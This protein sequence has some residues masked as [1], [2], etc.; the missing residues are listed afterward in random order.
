MQ[1]HLT[2]SQ[3]ITPAISHNTSTNSTTEEGLPDLAPGFSYLLGELQLSFLSIL[4]LNNYS[5]LLQWRRILTLILTST[6][7]VNTEPSLYISTL[8]LLRLQLSHSTDVEG[9]LFDFDDEGGTFLKTLLLRF[10]RGLDSL[11]G[12]TKAEVLEELEELQEWLAETHG[13][14]FDQG[15]GTFARSGVLELE[16][17]E[18]VDMDVGDFDEE[19]EEGEYAPMVVDLSDEQQRLLGAEAMNAGVNDEGSGAVKEEKEKSL[20]H[21]LKQETAA[22]EIAPTEVE[23]ED[24]SDLEGYENWDPEDLD[25]R[26]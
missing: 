1:T 25:A 19:D 16:D 3:S 26:Y 5:C 14:R 15:G 11:S 17:G 13:W 8:S 12:A 4:T 18:R 21:R 24:E 2:S 20:V 6:S 9:G 10:S 7:L 22:K 23:T